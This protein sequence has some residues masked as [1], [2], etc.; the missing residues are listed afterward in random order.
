MKTKSVLFVLLIITAMLISCAYLTSAEA[1]GVNVEV[2]SITVNSSN[3]N[4]SRTVAVPIKVV[5][6]S[7]MVTLKLDVSYSEELTLV[8][9]DKGNVFTNPSACFTSTAPD[10][11]ACNPFRILYVDANTEYDITETGTLLTLNFK[12]PTSLTPN[13]TFD[14]TLTGAEASSISEGLYPKSVAV[15]TTSG[16]ISV[17]EPIKTKL[18]V[19]LGED[20]T[21]GMITSSST[22]YTGDYHTSGTS[23]KLTATPNESVGVFGYW[24]RETLTSGVAVYIDSA[25]SIDA[26]PLGTSVAYQPVFFR[27]GEAKKTLYI[28]ITNKIL[29]TDTEPSAPIK[30][31][32]IFAGW[33]LKSSTDMLDVFAPVYERDTSNKAELTVCLPNLSETVLTP[34]FNELVTLDAADDNV[35][36]TLTVGE[37]SYPVSY[38]RYYS[39]RYRISYANATIAATVTEAN[40]TALICGLE[41]VR[42]GDSTRFVG[43]YYIP[44]NASLKSYGMLM[45]DNGS[46]AADMT[47]R[48]DGIIVGNIA[49]SS[50]EPQSQLF[51]VTKNKCGTSKW[52]A[53]PF[54][55]YTTPQA[56]DGI[57]VYSDTITISE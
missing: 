46:I 55:I 1:N 16:N 36:W 42:D 33:A 20:D 47:V 48:T 3:D 40:P 12:L 23:V 54:L 51:M 7:G 35:V 39:F 41:A 56:P 53:R 17:K 13:D 45:T 5:A 19:T 37:N 25:N 43:A 38:G 8:S 57:V 52:Y 11:L 14:I 4:N 28:D 10:D 18:E 34:S 6:N 50:G 27:V 29:S 31:G 2:E 15:I 26:Y 30:P 21:L 44:E 9:I 22:E 24:K 49:N 32:Y